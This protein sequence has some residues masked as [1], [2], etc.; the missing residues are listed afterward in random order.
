M[1]SSEVMEINR[2][3]FHLLLLLVLILVKVLTDSF[4]RHWQDSEE[5]M[6]GSN[7][8]VPERFVVVHVVD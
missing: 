5:T 3:D 7:V 4:S 2:D 1:E 8:H 6:L